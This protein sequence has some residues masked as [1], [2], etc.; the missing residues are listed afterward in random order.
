MRGML[1]SIN[2]VSTYAASS[3]PLAIGDQQI[4]IVG[5]FVNIPLFQGGELYGRLR[6]ARAQA[7]QSEREAIATE[8]RAHFDL[9]RAEPNP[10][11]S[12]LEERNIDARAHRLAQ[13]VGA[14]IAGDAHNLHVL[15]ET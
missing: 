15:P 1:P 14:R 10:V 3:E 9:E 8:H 2:A 7:R 11:R 12:L 5:A 4:W 13:R 6:A